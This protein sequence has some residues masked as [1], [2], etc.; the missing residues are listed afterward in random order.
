M[1][2]ALWFLGLFG[3]AVAIAL[4]AGNN[5][6]AVSVFWPPYRVDLSVNLV[7]LLLAL[8]FVV[9][10]LALRALAALFALPGLARRWRIQH[11]ERTIHLALLDALAHLIAGRFVRARKAAETVLGRDAAM[12]NSGEALT[13]S[14]HLRALAHLLAAESAQAL[15]DK[16]AREAHLAQALEQTARRDGQEI[17]DGVQLR[18]AHW[19]LQDHDA[20]GALRLLDE[21][22]Q[23]TARRTLALRLR[24]RAARAAR[25]PLQALETARLLTKHRAFSELAARGLLRALALE[26]VATAHDS[27]QMKKVWQQLDASERETPEVAMEACRRLLKLGAD[28]DLA[29]SWLQPMW[30]RM[31]SA[32]GALTEVQR[33]NLV[34]LL[35]SGFRLATA[36]AQNPWLTRIEQAQMADPGDPVLQYLAGSMCLR[37]Q[38]WGKAQ[39]LIK[40]ALPRLQNASLERSAWAALAELA[41]QRG[42]ADGA[43]QAWKSGAQV[44]ER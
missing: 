25:Q 43:A 16:A 3:V 28:A 30:E 11:Q 38:L 6:G 22:A 23:G 40:Q 1:R 39:Q 18:A 44:A 21:L 32:G 27:D 7:L 17:R 19:A 4:F 13:Y 14:A 26:L 5:Q 33:V 34:Q 42:D 29:L 12:K 31:R 2:A 9:L 36:D 10:H 8:L 20:S 35:E 37:L 15:R 41:Q 24:L